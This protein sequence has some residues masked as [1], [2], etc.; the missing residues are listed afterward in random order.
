MRILLAGGG[1]RWFG[2]SAL[3]KLF[4]QYEG[5]STDHLYREHQVWDLSRT[6][7]NLLAHLRCENSAVPDLLLF[8]KQ[9]WFLG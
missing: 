8:T 3:H 5:S 7:L 2:G 4:L 1:F 6:C 9:F